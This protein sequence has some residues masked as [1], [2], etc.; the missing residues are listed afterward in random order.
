VDRGFEISEKSQLKYFVN[1]LDE[2]FQEEDLKMLGQKKRCITWTQEKL[3]GR[4]E[5]LEGTFQ[6]L[7][8]YQEQGTPGRGKKLGIKALSIQQLK[9]NGL[10]F[11]C[12]KP[13]ILKDCP[14]HEAAREQV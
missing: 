7:A 5:E 11:K 14:D 2:T 3:V 12:E 1:G 8:I 13:G 10:C 6:T 4:L 9:S